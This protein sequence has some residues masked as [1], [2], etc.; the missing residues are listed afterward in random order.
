MTTEALPVRTGD[1][2]RR[3]T[4]AL[5]R[6][7]RQPEPERFILL[8]PYPITPADAHDTPISLLKRMAANPKRRG[9]PFAQAHRL[10]RLAG[11][12][13]DDDYNLVPMEPR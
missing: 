11:F 2:R 13:R 4:A 3:L 1:T 8:I 7:P 10:T 6:R 9:L 12:E 5:T